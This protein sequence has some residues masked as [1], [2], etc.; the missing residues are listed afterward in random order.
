[1]SM[2]TTKTTRMQEAFSLFV[3]FGGAI[4]SVCFHFAGCRETEGY[5]PVRAGNQKPI[6]VRLNFFAR[7]SKRSDWSAEDG[8]DLGIRG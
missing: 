1:M 4:V 3:S 7:S 8:C 6:S 5:F 2:E